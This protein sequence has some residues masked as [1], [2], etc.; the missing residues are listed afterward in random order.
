MDFPENTY[1]I[2]D[3]ICI[4]HSWYTIEAGVNDTLFFVFYDS[5]VPADYDINIPAGNYTGSS[6]AAQINSGLAILKLSPNALN[7]VYSI[8]ENNIVISAVYGIYTFQI[9]TDWELSQPGQPYYKQPLSSIPSLNDV[10]RN[11]SNKAS[12]IY[13]VTSP[14]ISGFLN[15]TLLNNI[16]MSSPNLGCFSTLTANGYQS[17]I[18]KIPITGD[19]GY[20]IID[21]VTAPHDMLEC[22]RV[23][24]SSI[25]FHLRD[26][27]GRY[28]P[29]HGSSVSF[30][31]IFV[32]HND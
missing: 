9:V 19:F 5:G 23:T 25:E 15:L 11:Y 31:I 30:T 1:F 13:N 10:L 24:L 14:F 3:D 6:L 21:K 7:A 8:S 29:L 2:I 32:Q 4:P 20:M 17:V 22:S 16:Y 26:C 28:I 27:D 12:T 18:K